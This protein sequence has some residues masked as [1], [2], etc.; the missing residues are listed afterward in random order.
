MKPSRL[1][2]TRHRLT[3][4][5]VQFMMV[6]AFC[7]LGGALQGL[8]LLI[9]LAG[10][11]LSVIVIQWRTS[12]WMIDSVRVVRRFPEAMFAGKPER[13]RYL[14]HN[15][16]RVAPMWLLRVDD[17]L[18][19]ASGAKRLEMSTGVGMVLP[20]QTTK[21]HFDLCLLRRGRYSL[22]Q[23][24]V[25]TMAPFALSRAWRYSRLELRMIPDRMVDQRPEDHQVDVYPRLLPLA[26]QW[27]RHL[28]SQ[29]GSVSN[30]ARRQGIAQDEFFG[31]R[32]YQ[33]GDSPR[34]IHW[35]T[36]ARI[37]YPAVRQFEQQ[38]RLDL[39]LLLD[40]FD[41]DSKRGAALEDVSDDSP[42]ETAISL[43]ASLVVGLSSGGHGQ[44]ALA[45]ADDNTYCVAGGQSHEGVRR[46]LTLLART[47]PVS[48]PRLIEALNA[49][50][51][52]TRRARDLVI[53][54]PRSHA[55]AI[56][57][58]VDLDRRLR[59]WN[60]Q[61]RWI[62]INVQDRDAS[63]WIAPTEKGESDEPSRQHVA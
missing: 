62:W 27:H 5:G 56:D 45:V 24:Q 14:I 44:T 31:L 20:Q 51:R 9:A 6:G 32:E 13:V 3:R 50:Q 28:P 16:S 63:R 26:R 42:V 43:A 12:R 18:L 57:E 48:S 52:S 25:S 21:T 61:G 23:W 41:A 37:G 35:R 2:S 10:V 46:M 47:E 4:L 19:D 22:G 7:M 36:T 60:R 34:H 17:V 53:I 11:C 40:S 54:S 58:D 8:N 39:T 59:A 15:T 30:A 38:R 33:R 55:E 29:L 49:A 1:R